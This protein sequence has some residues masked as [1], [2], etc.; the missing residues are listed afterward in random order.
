MLLYS[1]DICLPLMS[2]KKVKEV[3]FFF[4]SSV[5]VLLS[6]QCLSFRLPFL[7]TLL[8]I[9]H[10][11]FTIF[12]YHNLFLCPLF[13]QFPSFPLLNLSSQNRNMNKSNKNKPCF[14]FTD[15]EWA[16]PLFVVP[17]SQIQCDRGQVHPT[18]RG[19]SLP[20]RHTSPYTSGFLWFTS[21]CDCK[22]QVGGV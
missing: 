20:G 4:G 6:D 22:L 17:W 13:R 11:L 5:F 12:L 16:N 15:P 19:L 18:W 1:P 21:A 9:I 2:I 7:F 10:S 8:Y 14:V 3:V